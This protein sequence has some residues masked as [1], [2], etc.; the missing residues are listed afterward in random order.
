MGQSNESS[1]KVRRREERHV[2]R[3]GLMVSFA[4]HALIF[5]LWRHAP[6]PASPFAA[7]GPRAG[8]NRAAAGGMQA[9][10]VQAPPRVPIPPP[11]VPLPS[12]VDVD[13]VEFDPDPAL[14]P[15]SI[16]GDSPGDAVGPG[17]ENGDGRGDG[18]TAEEGTFRLVPPSPRGMIL[19]PTSRD[20]KG[21]QVEV[22]VFVD[23]TGRV[24]ADSTRLNPPTSNRSF[25]E[26]L[27]R[28]AAQW[29]FRPA[30]QGGEAVAAWFPYTISM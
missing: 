24:V 6:I 28:E 3:R 30:R 10:N 14:D 2:W 11:P 18:G 12:V 19:P 27:I 17:L 13:P 25:N 23:I 20:L 22:W 26:R 4:I 21:K 8:D 7:A 16:L 5:L 1:V 15:G 29:V 9:L